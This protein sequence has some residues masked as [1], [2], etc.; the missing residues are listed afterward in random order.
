MVRLVVLISIAAA[1]VLTLVIIL[2]VFCVIVS[3][4]CFL[5]TID[6]RSTMMSFEHELY[7]LYDIVST[8]SRLLLQAH[9]G[10]MLILCH[11]ICP[12]TWRM[13]ERSIRKSFPYLIGVPPM[14]LLGQGGALGQ[15]FE[16]LL[17]QVDFQMSMF[18]WRQKKKKSRTFRVCWG[19]KIQSDLLGVSHCVPEHH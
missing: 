10:V 1:L 9:T 19:K 11:E 2:A 18:I 3:S 17:R 13:E 6:T 8:G 15:T 14:S 16:Q 7:A 12:I 4:F 5:D